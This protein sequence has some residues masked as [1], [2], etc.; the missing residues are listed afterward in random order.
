MSTDPYSSQIENPPENPDGQTIEDY[1]A[2]LEAERESQ[3]LRIEAQDRE[4]AALREQVAKMPVVVGYVGET[5]FNKL[6]TPDN[7]LKTVSVEANH[8]DDWKH[9]VYLDPPQE[10]VACRKCY[11]TGKL[12][13][14]HKDD[15][16]PV[17]IC[18]DCKGKKTITLPLQEQGDE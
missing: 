2:W 15:N 13:T 7:K 4:I 6:L 3:K 9:P 17:I 5:Q 18:P 12:Y 16:D 14:P 11:G 8:D 10:Q 1:V